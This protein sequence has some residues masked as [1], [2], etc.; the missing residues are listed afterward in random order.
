MDAERHI[1]A[2]LYDDQVKQRV[3]S[4]QYQSYNVTKEQFW[5]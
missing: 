3:K 2:E 1:L 4:I 5:I